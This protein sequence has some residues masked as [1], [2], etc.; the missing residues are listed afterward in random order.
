[1]NATP[2]L[3]LLLPVAWLAFDHRTPEAPTKIPAFERTQHTGTIV[4]WHLAADGTVSVKLNDVERPTP[5]ALWF[6][7][8]ADKTDST[9]FEE[10]L[11]QAL[12]PVAA[13]ERRLSVVYDLDKERSGKTLEDGFPIVAVFSGA[14]MDEIVPP[15]DV[16]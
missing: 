4:A 6:R 8:P 12:L 5:E 1:M 2:G 11:L 14:K 10:L 13:S 16:R 3:F 15:K 7:S 9:R